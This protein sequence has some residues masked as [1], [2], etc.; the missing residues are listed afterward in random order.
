MKLEA[1]PEDPKILQECLRRSLSREAA[2]KDALNTV[3]QE[4]ADE[5]YDEICRTIRRVLHDLSEQS[6]F[7]EELED[8]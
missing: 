3:Y 8:N 4:V 5:D 7:P 1:L 2:L 6:I